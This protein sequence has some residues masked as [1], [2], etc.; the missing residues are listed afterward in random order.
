MSST[1]FF[2]EVT[3]DAPIEVFEITRQFNEDTNPSKVNL[4]VGGIL[5]QFLEKKSKIFIEYTSAY[6]DDNGKPWVLPVVRT[7][8]QQVASDL[9]L[10]HEYLPVC[11]L[12][13]FS[14]A[15]VK[16]VLGNDSPAVISNRV[17]SINITQ[18]KILLP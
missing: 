9:T 12:Q 11:G 5:Q 17:R 14:N 3:Q 10:D 7:V 2:S 8:E 18:L 15:A 4:G 1:G 6:K 16:L 13:S